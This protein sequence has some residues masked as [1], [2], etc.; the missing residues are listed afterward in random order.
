MQETGAPRIDRFVSLILLVLLGL[1]LVFFIDINP[2]ILRASLGGDLPA[3]TVSWLLIA[4]LVLVSVTGADVFIRQH[5]EMQRRPQ[6]G[7]RLG[8]R[9]IELAPAFWILPAFTVI[10]PFAFFRL[11]V[12]PFG[13]IVFVPALLCSGGLLLATLLAHHY[14]L[15]RRAEIRQRATAAIQVIGMLLAF[16][17]FGAVMFARM[18][19]LY[20]AAL[21]G[22]VAALL[23]YALLRWGPQRG[24]PW[25]LAGAIGLAIAETTWPINYWAMPALLAGGLLFAV[26]YTV[27]GLAQHAVSGQLTRAV[28]GEYAVVGGAALAVSVYWAL[29]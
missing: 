28:I 6:L 20:A 16:A 4:A 27:V 9:T 21:I 24:T 7:L 26:F 19:T 3:I 13:P 22:A 14:A 17:T 11:F 15:D 25:M 18:R 23:A 2:S 8:G 5:P 12:A 29:R 10:A 1:A